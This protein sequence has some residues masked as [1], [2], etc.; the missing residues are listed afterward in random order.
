MIRYK[1]GI[2]EKQTYNTHLV[3]NK[4]KLENVPIKRVCDLA[5]VP[6]AMFDHPRMGT[7]TVT[8]DN[9]QLIYVRR[10]L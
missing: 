5:L 2:L 6:L 9:N 8:I 7:G 10:Q 3:K 1:T 4:K